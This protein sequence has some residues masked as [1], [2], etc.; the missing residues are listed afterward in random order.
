[1]RSLETHTLRALL[2]TR[3]QLVGMSTAVIN[4]IR[5]LA[6]TFG[7]L[8]GPGKGRTFERQVRA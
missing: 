8:I 1:M 2:I 4:K 7:L 5:G 6:K 3:D